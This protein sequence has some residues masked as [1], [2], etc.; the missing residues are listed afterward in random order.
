MITVGS[1]KPIKALRRP[2]RIE[3]II[4]LITVLFALY[5]VVKPASKRYIPRVP[6]YTIQIGCSSP[7]LRNIS[8][9]D[10]L[11]SVMDSAI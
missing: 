7:Y 3:R 1:S 5:T 4:E 11:I 9:H 2:I 10:D 8:Q 6:Y